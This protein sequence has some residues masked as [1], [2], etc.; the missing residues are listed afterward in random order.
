M[1]PSQLRAL[2][3]ICLLLLASPA[4][5]QPP[6]ANPFP[7]RQ[8]AQ[9]FVL[10]DVSGSYYAEATAT[11]EEV[12]GVLNS[13]WLRDRVSVGLIQSCS[14]S[15][16]ALIFDEPM[17]ERES[18]LHRSRAYYRTLWHTRWGEVRRALDATQGSG[19]TDIRGAV[20]YASQRMTQAP[21]G[22]RRLL[23]IYSDMVEDFSHECE[24]PSARGI[25]LNNIDVIIAS[26]IRTPDD[27]RNPNRYAERAARWRQWFTD[28]GA[29]NVRFVA[30][31]EVPAIVRAL[32]SST[33]P[34]H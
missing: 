5:A 15:D 7:Q 10:F 30:R 8:A 14:F 27:T 13:V 3:G 18:A 2:A 21:A 6:F 16:R 33:T 1:I 17:P 34:A 4:S 28:R 12:T 24:Q 29:S 32:R 11:A 22:G 9:Y 25:R 23:V 20:L 26:M 31:G 19:F